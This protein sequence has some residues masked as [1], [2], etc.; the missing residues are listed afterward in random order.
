MRVSSSR[1]SPDRAFWP[2]KRVEHGRLQAGEAEDRP[3]VV[4]EGPGKGKRLGVAALR[5]ALDRGT[6]PDIPGPGGW[7][8]CRTPRRPRRRSCRPAASTPAGSAVVEAGV[9][10]RDHQADAGIDLAIRV[11]ELAGVQVAFQ[12]VDGDQRD[13]QRHRQGLGRRQADDQG[14]DQPRAGRD[15]DRVQVAERHAG[16][17]QGLVDHRQD[18]ADVCP[19]GDLGHD[20][21]VSL[22]QADLRGH[23]ARTDPRHADVRRPR[24][25]EDRRRRLVAGR[26]DGQQEVDRPLLCPSPG[27]I[28]RLKPPWPWCPP[29]S[30]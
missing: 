24:T 5:H 16:P 9:S 25:L 29:W 14:T 23:D 20:A 30:G 3:I 15:G 12:V 19:R 26:F 10:S 13:V 6:R 17:V 1:I 4:Q 11:G 2:S 22:M 18:L 21:A 28:G 8:P 27:G 7:P